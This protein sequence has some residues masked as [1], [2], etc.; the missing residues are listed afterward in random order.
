M[1]T[2]LISP[3][4][5]RHTSLLGAGDGNNRIQRSRYIGERSRSTRGNSKR[6]LLRE[7]KQWKTGV[8]G[9]KQ[10]L[11]KRGNYIVLNV[12]ELNLILYRA[13]Y[14]CTRP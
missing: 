9:N 4:S 8:P 10:L 11:M 5:I 2:L 1:S 6:P 14:V 3:L 12:S 7:H 13:K